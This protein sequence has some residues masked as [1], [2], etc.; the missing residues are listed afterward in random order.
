[1]D[2]A[3]RQGLLT[4]MVLHSAVYHQPS[5]LHALL[6]SVYFVTGRK[7]SASCCLPQAADY[8]RSR[9]VIC[10]LQSQLPRLATQ[11]VAGSKWC[12]DRVELDFLPTLPAAR[13]D[14]KLIF[15]SW[16]DGSAVY[17]MVVGSGGCTA[18]RKEI[19]WLFPHDTTSKGISLTSRPSIGK[20]I[21]TTPT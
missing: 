17:A 5:A 11:V 3:S 16:A 10:V 21:A 18:F 13:A 8:H 2:L 14:R 15:Q 7:S 9:N 4:H 1:M 12:S 19:D 6:P 20:K